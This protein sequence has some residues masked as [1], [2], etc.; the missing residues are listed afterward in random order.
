M[1]NVD[2]Y[3]AQG[4]RSVKLG[5]RSVEDAETRYIEALEEYLGYTGVG[6]A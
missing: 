2:D 4:V 6:V 1:A 3:A 5:H